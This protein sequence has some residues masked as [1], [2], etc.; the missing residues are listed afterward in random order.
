MIFAHPLMTAPLRQI[1]RWRMRHN[2]PKGFNKVLNVT[3]EEGLATGAGVVNDKTHSGKCVMSSR[4][5]IA[6][7]GPDAIGATVAAALHEAGRTPALCG[8]TARG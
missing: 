7:I 3:G 1:N 6:L 5:A 2:A 8:R 4:P